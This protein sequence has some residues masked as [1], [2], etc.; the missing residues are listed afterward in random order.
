MVWLLNKFSSKKFIFNF[1][2]EN[3]FLRNCFS[4]FLYRS[5]INIEILFT[6]SIYDLY[7]SSYIGLY[8]KKKIDCVCSWI[9]TGSKAC[10]G[11]YFHSPENMDVEEGLLSGRRTLE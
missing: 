7:R 3:K 9:G 8:R 2:F 10:K 6:I 5:Y 1:T 4:P 11:C